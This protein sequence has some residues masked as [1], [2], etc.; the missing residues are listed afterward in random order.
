MRKDYQVFCYVGRS[1]SKKVD[2]LAIGSSASSGED[3]IPSK[4]STVSRVSTNTVKEAEANSQV[5]LIHSSI[6]PNVMSKNHRQQE[7]EELLDIAEEEDL[8]GGLLD[9]PSSSTNSRLAASINMGTPISLEEAT[10][11]KEIILGTN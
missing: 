11:L 8:G 5:D 4:S 1:S 2:W 3:I 7:P 6:I 9:R 10:A